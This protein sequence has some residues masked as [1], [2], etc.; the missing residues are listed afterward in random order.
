ME[1]LVAQS[2]HPHHVVEVRDGHAG[3]DGSGVYDHVWVVE[4]ESFGVSVGETLFAGAAE[5][6]SCEWF[7][8]LHVGIMMEL[9]Y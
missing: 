6:A 5:W 3:D 9:S 7:I 4:E 8:V 2:H 1:H